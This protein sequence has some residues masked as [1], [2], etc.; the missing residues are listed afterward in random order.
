VADAVPSVVVS[1]ADRSAPDGD[2]GA[3]ARERLAA[4]LIVQ[5]EEARLPAA[6]ASVAFCDEVIV[7]DGGSSDRTIEIARSAGATVIENAWPGYAAQRNVGID[8]AVSDWVL[9]VDADERVSPALRASIEALLTAPPEGVAMAVCA[10]RERLLGAPLGPAAKYPSYCSRLFRPEVYRHDESRAVH[11]GLALRERPLILD[12]DLE[13]EL[14]GSVRELLMD[15]W[16]YAQLE[17]SHVASPDSAGG[18]L[19]GIVLRPAAKLLYRTFVDGG[20]RDGW[21]GLMK[22][23]LDVASDALVWVLVLQRGAT[24]EPDPTDEPASGHFG[25]RKAGPPRIVAVA[26]RGGPAGRATRWLA[27]LQAAGADVVLISDQAAGDEEIPHQRV[28][29]IGP[30]A[31]VRALDV[32][33]QARIADAVVPFGRRAQLLQRVM[34]RSLRPEI[35]GLGHEVDAAQALKLTQRLDGPDD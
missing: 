25:R 26:A 7:I 33:Q 1:A 30:V 19:V 8:A 3:S 10:R 14:A 27:D 21:R 11:E 31:L 28:Q 35:P 6:L 18:Y 5:D 34:P 2:R 29:R 32:V 23:S 12:G 9:E 15:A 16:R 24:G 13:H 17:S 22:I 20:W 4:C